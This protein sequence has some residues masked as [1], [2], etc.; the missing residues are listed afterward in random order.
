MTEP[1]KTLFGDD[2]PEH[3]RPER[4]DLT[5]IRHS[6]NGIEIGQRPIDG[7]CNATAM[8]RAYQKEFW[9]WQDLPDVNR[10][11]VAISKETD[12][13][14]QSPENPGIGL[15]QIRRGRYGGTW[16][17]PLVAVELAR[18]LD[19]DFGVRVNRWW[20]DWA[21]GR[22]VKF[23]AREVDPFVIGKMIAAAQE[24]AD[25]AENKADRA[26]ATAKDAHQC[27][28]E[29][30]VD[31]WRVTQEF[32]GRLHQLEL[33]LGPQPPADRPHPGDWRT[34]RPVHRKTG[35]KI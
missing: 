4:P 31:H 22:P 5:L 30:Q 10:H 27:A 18:W 2:A 6:E 9:D 13:L 8:C 29:T 21:R 26:L 23:S 14:V 28:S 16:V 7:Y 32:E 12:L 35:G 24:T 17:H 1:A 15:I 33:E 20:L 11:L 3:R 19:P 25:R 34:W